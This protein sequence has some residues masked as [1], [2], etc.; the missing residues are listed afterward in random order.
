MEDSQRPKYT[1]IYFTLPKR[2]QFYKRAFTKAATIKDI[3]Y[4]V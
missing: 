4:N 2:K 3:F 1:I